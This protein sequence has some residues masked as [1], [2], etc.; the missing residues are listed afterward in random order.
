[1]FHTH[2]DEFCILLYTPVQS[3]DR[4]GFPSNVSAPSSRSNG[5]SVA[6]MASVLKL[7][8]ICSSETSIDFQQAALHPGG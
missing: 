5:N 1:M 3:V 8:A 7:E 6:Q 2:V 4:A